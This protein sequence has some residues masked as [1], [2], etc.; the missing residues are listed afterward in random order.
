MSAGLIPH[1][2]V[3]DIDSLPSRVADELESTGVEVLRYPADKDLTDL[4]LAIG[5]VRALK[6]TAV[7]VTGV[8]AGR[9]DH[10]L[11]AVGSLCRAVDLDVEVHEPDAR[12]WVV[13]DGGDAVLEL[14][15]VDSTVSL[16]A[17]LGPAIVSAKGVRWPLDR[18]RLDPLSSLGVSNRIVGEVAFV[19]VH[20]GTVLV[21]SP[22]VDGIGAAE[23]VRRHS[24]KTPPGV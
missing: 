2:V 22:A 20:S 6:P 24:T 14:A 4:D 1:V 16:L 15:G 18:V 23:C 12:G 19:E 7:M 13:G 21:S 5:H 11:A 17:S 3:G 10:T 9:V 8:L